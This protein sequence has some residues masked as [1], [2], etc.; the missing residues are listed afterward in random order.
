M[1]AEPL[2]HCVYNGVLTDGRKASRHLDKKDHTQPT[3]R[4]GPRQLHT[5]YGARLR[6][7]RQR[8]DLQKAANAGHDPERHF[9]QFLHGC[10]H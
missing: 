5:E 8:A 3:K 6:R 9:E 4:D 2:T 10:V 7:R 1:K